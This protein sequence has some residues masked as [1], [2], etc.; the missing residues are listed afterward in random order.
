[1]NEL[2]RTVEGR[3]GVTPFRFIEEFCQLGRTLQLE[4][5]GTRMKEDGK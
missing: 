2:L 4:G 3:D 1:M 5:E